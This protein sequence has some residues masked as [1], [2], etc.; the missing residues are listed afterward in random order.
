MCR[1]S[2]RNPG[3]VGKFF[4]NLKQ[5]HEEPSLFEPMNIYKVDKTDL[6]TAQQPEKILV[7]KCQK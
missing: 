5:A 6:E 4:K 1:A 2:A 3:C 7:P